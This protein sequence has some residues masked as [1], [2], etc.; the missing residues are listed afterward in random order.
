MELEKCSCYLSI[1]DFQSDGYAFTRPP[2][3]IAKEIVVKDLAG[4]D[5]T[6]RQLSSDKSQ[7]LLGVMRNPI[8]NQQDEIERLKQKSDRL[9][10]Q[11]NIGALS[12]VQAKMAYESFFLPAM[13]YSLPITAINQMDL[14]G[15]QKKATL[16]TLASLGYNRHMPREV[17]FCSTKYQGIGLQ[18]LYDVQGSEGT[19]LILQELKHNGSTRT[20]LKYLLE[21]IQMESG[22]GNPILQDTRPLIYIE[23]GWVPGIRDFLHHI[24]GQIINASP[25]PT[26]Y[27][28][29]DSY[30]MDAPML[31]TLSRKEQILINRCR[32]YLQVE[33]ISD[34]CNADG[35]RILEDWKFANDDP[36]SHSTKSW[37]RQGDPGE[38]AWHIWRSFLGKAF[39]TTSGRLTMTLG[40]WININRHRI[41]FAYYH[42]GLQQLWVYENEN[43]WTLHEKIKEERRVMTFNTK[44]FS[45]KT[46][47]KK[48]CI[49]IHIIKIS[50]T[51]ITTSR[52]G[53]YQVESRT[54]NKQTSLAQK[55]LQRSEDPL[56][57][58][59]MITV[60][61]ADIQ[62][63]LMKSAT[64]DI[65]SDGS[66]NRNNGV[67][68][69][70]WIIAMNTTMI[71]KAQGP[72][73]AHQNMSTPFRAEIYGIASATSF[74]R[75]MFDHYNDDCSRHKWFFLLDNTTVIHQM[76][77]LNSTTRTA[78]WQLKPEADILEIA[79]ERLT[80]IPAN[81]VH[82][83]SHQDRKQ[84]TGRLSYDAQ[85]NCL[86]DEL[87]TQQNK[88]M[89]HPYTKQYPNCAHLKIN[90]MIVT[91]ESKAW[92]MDAAG[93]I[94]IQQYYHDRYKWTSV[95]FDSI[96]WTAQKAVLARY[97]ANDQRRILKFVHGWL[98][99][100]NRLYREKQT[101]TQQ[102]PLCNYLIEDNL[103]MFNCRHE[104]QRDT[105]RKM[106]DQLQQESGND[107]KQSL[108]TR[109]IRGLKEGLKD[110]TWQ[111]NP[112]S[113]DQ[114]T[115]K[116][117]QEQN[118]IGW[119]QMLYGRTGIS[120]T[121]AISALLQRQ[122][123]ETWL[124]SGEKWTRR[125]IQILWDTVLKL[126]NNRNNIIHNGQIMSKAERQRE[127]LLA[128]VDKCYEHKDRLQYNDRNKLF[129]RDKEVLM[130]EDPRHIKA[131]L[132]LS[133]RI[134][135]VSKREE[136]TQRFAKTMMEQ[137]FTWK[138]ATKLKQK[139]I[140]DQHWKHDLK[141]D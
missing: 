93:K 109:I 49:P 105:V 41:H 110:L 4:N 128:R 91:R 8:G 26:I 90:N 48:Q 64:F 73:A 51:Q 107:D 24:N 83:K 3:D 130:T 81:Y 43:A 70:G 37:P 72:V 101:N 84:K 80:K 15:I 86:A 114:L 88:K 55:I 66:Y 45:I 139:Q 23:W 123:I 16:A 52:A 102:C 112:V 118:Q 57:H 46:K 77:Q 6:I 115:S 34:I 59:I 85:L 134:I 32:L 103:H 96:H 126:W 137:Y 71:A 47:L 50:D 78:K 122:G 141:P 7:K 69:F 33:C 100:Y 28:R 60:D 63:Q 67:A 125:I 140:R 58:N 108:V 10:H 138:P 38:E 94:P 98:P 104:S 68:S 95:V 136:N 44:T 14:E 124:I 119:Y 53:E 21:V 97:E 40:P 129:T 117:I 75:L 29:N 120:L 116:W 2:D 1:W 12:T 135:R 82:V 121:K 89:K 22:I 18:H 39:G 99:T 111:A 54:T 79:A 17:V 131:W 25:K 62:Q 92:L 35:S 5:R 11:I 106:F 113:Q 19:R 61:E 20:M 31:S 13:R 27:R 56:F 127:R 87:A 133:E 132:R 76:E 30:I 36:P 65:A 42:H 74:I 9:A